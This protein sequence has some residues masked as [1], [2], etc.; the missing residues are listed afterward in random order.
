M[1]PE[2]LLLLY[3]ELRAYVGLTADD[4]EHVRAVAPLIRPHLPVL[5]D[6]F[7]DE[8][9]R[10]PEAV[11]VITGGAEQIERLKEK[12]R[13]WIEDLLTAKCDQDYVWRHS[14]VGRRH[15]EIGLP[16]VYTNA[17]M[18]RLR[19]GFN[20]I[21]SETSAADMT[22]IQAAARGLNK[23]I[24]LDLAI[25]EDAYQAEYLL[26]QDR[27]RRLATIGEISGGIAHELRNPLGIMRN[28]VYFLR[29]SMPA[30][31]EDE[32][33]AFDEL[34]RGLKNCNRLVSELLDFVREPT[35]EESTF[36]LAEAIEEALAGVEIPESVSL[37][38][39]EAAGD[40]ICRA[41]KRQIG[42]IINNLVRNAVEA[43]PRGGVL[44][45]KVWRANNAILEVAD[46]GCGIAPGDLE[47]VFEPLFSRKAK[48]IGLG[49]A[50]SRRYA[51]R[52]QGSLSA[53]SAEGQGATFRLTIPIDG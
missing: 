36:C 33:D 8:L 53:E 35:R 47:K 49:L 52:N 6:D 3:E 16:Q 38:L 50:V 14:Q 30:R 18:S 13:D 19:S 2:K 31:N 32:R 24:D 43:M 10:H 48:G 39:P 15:V 22:E 29:M 4:L 20:R 40:V 21:L 5:V 44:T 12:L 9:Q 23:L 28:A 51:E 42:Q 17:A 34:E 45:L 7:Y 27:V 41:D 25:I 11:R 1:I 46:N 26:R 37:E